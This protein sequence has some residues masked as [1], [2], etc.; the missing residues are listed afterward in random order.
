[1]ILTTNSIKN[2]ISINIISLIK[3]IENNFYFCVCYFYKK[4]IIT[5]W[6]DL[7]KHNKPNI[8]I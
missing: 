7:Q 2:I 6:K 3:F 4:E 1:M 5:L 8:Q